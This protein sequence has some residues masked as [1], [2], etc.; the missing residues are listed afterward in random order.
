MACTTNV[1]DKGQETILSPHQSGKKSLANQF[2]S[3]FNQ[4]IKRIHY[5]FTVSSSTVTLPM[6]LP[7]NQFYF[8]E[9]SENEVLEIIKNSPTKSSSLDPVPTYLL[10]DS[11]D[12]LL[13]S[14][15]NLVNL[16][17]AEGVFPQKFKKVIVTLVIKKGSLQTTN[18]RT[19][20]HVKIGGAG[21]CQTV[22][23]TYQQ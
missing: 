4:K 23:G 14:I 1:L 11:M 19:M 12:I 10:K 16:A 7:P 18:I 6:Y 17:L 20:C 21:S 15:T 5:M 22:H 9:V 8:N 2:A 3:F 13:P